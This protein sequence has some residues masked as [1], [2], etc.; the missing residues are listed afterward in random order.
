MRSLIRAAH[1]A[2]SG[3]RV[4]R[5][6][7]K[8]DMRACARCAELVPCII[9]SHPP[10]DERS[11]GSDMNCHAGSFDVL[12]VFALWC[13][14]VMRCDSVERCCAQPWPE[15]GPLLLH[16][17]EDAQRRLQEVAQRAAKSIRAVV[18][19]YVR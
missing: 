6:H 16:H 13:G 19:R 17:I 5:R 3:R 14:S 2:Q 18:G 9:V 4:K 10:I 15:H 12:L 7:K 11:H 8:I 1:A